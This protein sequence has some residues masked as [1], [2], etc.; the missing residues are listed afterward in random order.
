MPAE[1]RIGGLAR[2]SSCDW[3]DEL[4]ATVFCQGCS[5]RCTYCHNRDLQPTTGPDRVPWPDV[6]HFLAG[7][8]GLLDGVVFSGGEPL[9]QHALGAAME[10][11]RALGFRIGLHTGGAVPS[12]LAAVLSLCD[13]VGFDLK[14]P[15]DDYAAITGVPDS[16]R[17]GR[18]SLRLLLASGVA[19]EIRTT[20]HP[21]LIAGETL[22][23]MAADLTTL[24]VRRWVLQPFRAYA[25]AAL[26]P[27]TYDNQVLAA[28]Q[29][30]PL[31]IVWR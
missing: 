9:L 3:P 29:S 22:L 14:A 8:V 7:R 6:L 5:W 12:R 30:L 16:G 21:R 31:P 28:L 17:D 26:M 27:E 15:F 25:G 11:A 18:E 23:R 2:L 10:Q 20:V 13:W 19:Y 1:L 24:G 4:V